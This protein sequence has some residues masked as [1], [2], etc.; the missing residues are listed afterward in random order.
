MGR[1]GRRLA[2]TRPSSA[3]SVAR[4]REEYE[5]ACFELRQ[6]RDQLDQT[7][8]VLRRL[9]DEAGVCLLPKLRRAV[10]YPMEFD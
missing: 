10:S 5:A 8:H 2:R 3:S 7:Q 9:E 6:L 1:F 4:A